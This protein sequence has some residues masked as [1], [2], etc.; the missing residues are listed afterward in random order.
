MKMSIIKNLNEKVDCNILLKMENLWSKSKC[1][2]SYKALLGFMEFG[3]GW[4]WW[5]LEGKSIPRIA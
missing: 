5:G 2:H 4:G 1:Y 3:L